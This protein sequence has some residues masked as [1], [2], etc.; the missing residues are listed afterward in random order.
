MKNAPS[1]RSW[2]SSAGHIACILCLLPLGTACGDDDGSTGDGMGSDGTRGT[3]GSS[4]DGTETGH[5]DSG[6]SSSTASSSTGPGGTAS[7]T[8]ASSTTDS[9]T[10]DATAGSTDDSTGS[11]DGTSGLMLDGCYDPVD[12]PY[13]GSL[14]GPPGMPCTV[15]V[16]EPVDPVTSFRNGAPS[17]VL[18]DACEPQVLYSVAE[19]GYHGHFARRT[20][21]G[22]WDDESTPFPVAVGGLAFDAATGDTLALPYDGA[23]GVTVWR[24]DG[25]GWAQEDTLAGSYYMR[26]RAV[27]QR[28]DG[29]LRAGLSTD[30]LEFFD[31]QWD[32]GWASAMLTGYTE[33]QTIGLGPGGTPHYSYWTSTGGGWRMSWVTPGSPPE[34]VATLGL[35]SGLHVLEN[36]IAVTPDGGGTPHIGFARRT[37]PGGLHEIV[38]ATRTAPDT[39]SLLTV[40]SEDP[41]FNDECS[42]DPTGP[43]EICQVDYIR[44]MPLD[45]VASDGGDVRIF[46]AEYHF[47]RT[48]QSSCSPGPGGLFCGWDTLVDDSIGTLHVAW[49]SAGSIETA[50]LLVGSR[51]VRS[52]TSAVDIEGRIHVAAYTTPV[53]QGELLTDYLRIG[54]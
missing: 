22:A 37:A 19:L 38:Y 8:T 12:F 7:G 9:T 5:S 47:L 25:G 32:G 2:A 39:W 42:Q 1:D 49:P 35:G 18:D 17:I 21:P 26:T 24:R 33:A 27:G 54:P 44:L 41:A 10:D 30:A 43:G 13:A 52:M 6:S 36:G 4:A 16:D 14:C 50:P 20:G 31:V 46:Y 3:T 51:F 40:A 34:Q 28:G 48:L 23:F 11:S 45:V 15:Q 29:T 53:G